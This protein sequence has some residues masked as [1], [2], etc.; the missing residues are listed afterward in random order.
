MNITLMSYNT[1]HCLNYVTRQIDYDIMAD[2]IKKCGAD[3][4]G[5]QEMFD[6][7]ETEEF[8][9]QTKVLA[10]KLGFYWYFAE[11]TKL[12]KGK[13]PYG[14]GLISRYP[15]LSAETIGIPDPG[16]RTGTRYYE[17]RCVLKAKINVPGGLDVL[18]THFGLNSDEQ[19][20]AV[21]T[22]IANLENEKCVLMGD[23]NVRPENERIKPI[24]ERLYDTAELFDEPK[25]SWPS[26]TP[27]GKIDYIFTTK[28]VKVLSADIPVIVSS[29]HRPHIATIELL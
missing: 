16:V 9:T 28:D 13:Y 1:Q 12:E 15:I 21:S 18:V 19:E 22:V 17:T 10:E 5:L 29:D 6:L 26:D 14:N 2:T 27:K 23:F 4:I 3:I 24:R 11:A 7:G 20:N 25:G 8:T